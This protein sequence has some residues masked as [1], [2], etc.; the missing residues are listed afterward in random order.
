MSVAVGVVTY[1]RKRRG[2]PPRSPAS[3]RIRP[4]FSS[5]KPAAAPDRSTR[6]RRDELGLFWSPPATS[7]SPAPVISAGG[8]VAVAADGARTT[9]TKGTGPSVTLRSFFEKKNPSA[10]DGGRNNSGS[11]ASTSAPPPQ[12]QVHQAHVRTRKLPRCECSLRVRCLTAV[13][14]FAGA[15][16][17][18]SAW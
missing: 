3:G 6:G 11:S 2:A 18:G 8:P 14:C 4:K 10:E 15:V 13:G 7:P 12:L 17:I 16:A 9:A 1:A 5:S